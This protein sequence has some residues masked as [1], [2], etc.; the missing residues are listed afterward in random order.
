[1]NKS[2]TDKN[3]SLYGRA[4]RG[5]RGKLKGLLIILL[6]IL[7]WIAFA[8]L[9]TIYAFAV[10][11]A[12]I[13]SF[14]VSLLTCIYVLSTNK[15]SQ[16][17]AVWIIFLLVCFTFGYVVFWLSDE[18]IFF[19]KN[20][21]R[22]TAVYRQSE[23]FLLENKIEFSS[24][25]VKQNAEFLYSTGKFVAYN[26]TDCKYFPSGESFF[27]DVIERIKQAKKFIFL[28]FFILSD[29][30]LL[31][32]I[33]E[34]LSQKVKE[35]VDVRI[36]YDDLGSARAFSLST[37]EKIKKSGIQLKAF[38]KMFPVFSVALNYRDHRKIIV[39]DGQT[40][41]TG[42]CNLA[43]EYINQKRLHG[44]WKD[45][46]VRIDGNAVDGF[47]IIFLRQ[48]EVLSKVRE[49]YSPFF[50]LY[51][52][53]QNKFTVIPYADGLDYSH[54][55]ARGVYENMII[56]ANEYLYIS[57]PYFIVDDGI[58]NL[59]MNKA[60]SG[61]D[62]RLVLPAIPDKKFVYGVSRSN[63]E[64]LIEYGVK[65][66]VFNDTFVHSKL[67]LTETAVAIGSVNMDLRSY[68]QQFESS[69]YTDD[70]K[71]C[72]DVKDDFNNMFNASTLITKETMLRKNV[73]YRLIVGLMQVFSPFM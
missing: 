13:F 24:V 67:L 7:P 18:R 36:I 4:V 69:I 15:N 30:L 48:W 70:H 2:K 51:I 52:P 65:V 22:Y 23:E 54:P 34:I 8:Y 58:T 42:G 60:L 46:G 56:S 10:T 57:T 73:F 37:K 19:K 3:K 62:V 14:A 40:A 20:K 26:S 25:A 66:Y 44:Y 39:I 31:D 6:A 1:M 59:L 63:A 64:K 21:K 50:N 61:V 11:G 27:D 53:T 28:E 71:V 16:S 41:Y 72:T 49:D 38:N 29:G 55:I 5:G 17:K 32:R 68:Y 43:D 33:L 9:H 47:T 35:G 45:S 12:L